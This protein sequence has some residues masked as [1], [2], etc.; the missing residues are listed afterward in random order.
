[1]Y[2]FYVDVGEFFATYFRKVLPQCLD[3]ERMTFRNPGD[4][5]PGRVISHKRRRT[6]LL[7]LQVEHF[8]SIS[9]RWVTRWFLSWPVVSCCFLTFGD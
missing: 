6:Q 8:G 9:K 1:M 2:V 4:L 5:S 7:H 3:L